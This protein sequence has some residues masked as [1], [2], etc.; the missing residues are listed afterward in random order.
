MA[1]REP[2]MDVLRRGLRWGGFAGLGVYAFAILTGNKSLY[3]GAAPTI[4]KYY[5]QARPGLFLD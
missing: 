4:G 1:T 2:F 5:L 3:T